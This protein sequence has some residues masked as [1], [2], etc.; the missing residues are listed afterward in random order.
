MNP[1]LYIGLI[2]EGIGA[3]GCLIFPTMFLMT[4]NKR[5]LMGAI[6]SLIMLVTGFMITIC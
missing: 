4:F 2:I 3:L 5:I 6:L 1:K